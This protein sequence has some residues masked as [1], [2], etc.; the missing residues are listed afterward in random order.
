VIAH[1]VMVTRW[2]RNLEK[3]KRARLEMIAS[4]Q[5][6][7]SQG[8]REGGEGAQTKGEQR[9]NKC[10]GNARKFVGPSFGGLERHLEIP[11]LEGR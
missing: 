10:F 6:V 2:Q 1:L 9:R 7:K 11:G 5:R 4:S 3:T 8:R